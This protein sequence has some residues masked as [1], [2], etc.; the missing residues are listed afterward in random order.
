MFTVS[1]CPD[2]IIVTHKQTWDSKTVRFNGTRQAGDL[3]CKRT[4]RQVAIRWAVI[5]GTSEACASLAWRRCEF[6]R[7][8]A[9]A[10]LTESEWVDIITKFYIYG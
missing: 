4:V 8:P 6:G 9:P 7:M 2:R 10:K 3:G 1:V 5:T